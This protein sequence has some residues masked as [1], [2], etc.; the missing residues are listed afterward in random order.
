ML[1][2]HKICIFIECILMLSFELVKPLVS[3][4]GNKN[5]HEYILFDLR[6]ITLSKK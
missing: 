4:N 1:K 5:V 3:V 2:K 6:N